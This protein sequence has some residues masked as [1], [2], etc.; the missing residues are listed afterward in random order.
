MENSFICSFLCPSTHPSTHSLYKYLLGT[1]HTYN[2]AWRRNDE[3]AS[4][5]LGAPGITHGAMGRKLAGEV[6][7][8]NAS[9]VPWMVLRIYTH[10][11]L[12]SSHLG[13][14]E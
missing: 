4:H 11:L 8:M 5:D 12:L 13:L 2:T 6:H 7:L 3:L 9:C 1:S 10:A 14:G